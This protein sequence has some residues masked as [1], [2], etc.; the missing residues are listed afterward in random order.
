MWRVGLVWDSVVLILLL[1]TINRLVGKRLVRS[2]MSPK[3]Q[4][5]FLTLRYT[6]NQVREL[7]GGDR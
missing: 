2:R 6:G 5:L 3:K 7:G 1:I 4:P